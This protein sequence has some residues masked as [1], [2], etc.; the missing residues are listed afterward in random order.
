MTQ[1]IR[2]MST[3]IS[4]FGS[5]KPTAGSSD[6]DKA[7]RLGV[8][9]GKRG[10]TICNGGYGGIMEASAKG[11][12]EAGADTIGVTVR[13]FRSHPNPYIKKNVTTVSLLERLEKLIDPA[14]GY[15]IFPGGTGTMVELALCWELQCKRII[16]PSRPIVLFGTHWL[17]AVRAAEEKIQ[18]ECV[19]TSHD[20]HKP[21]EKYMHVTETVEET[22]RLLSELLRDE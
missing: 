3:I 9:L 21:L 8:E 7:Y 5:R 15:V 16:T 17:P 11:A 14:S 22:V 2:I 6:Y 10:F 18:K 13:Q 4:I 19:P 12:V 1:K 20:P